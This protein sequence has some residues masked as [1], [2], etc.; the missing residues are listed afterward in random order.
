MTEEKA[1]LVRYLVKQG[2]WAF[3]ATALMAGGAY[4]GKMLLDRGLKHFD[5]VETVLE[6]H[7]QAM[8]ATARAIERM[9]LD[10]AT[11]RD[12]AVQKITTEVA[13]CCPRRR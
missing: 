4:A 1:T 2:A 8:T 7:E 12:S 6:R 5:R 13:R 10:S 9:S 11:G 3:V